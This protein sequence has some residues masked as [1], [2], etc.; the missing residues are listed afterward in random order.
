MSYYTD[1]E[2]PL[3]EDGSKRD[4]AK[5]SWKSLVLLLKHL[6]NNGV[7]DDLVQTVN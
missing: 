3:W 7:D 2:L 4:L 6:Q 1:T 5:A